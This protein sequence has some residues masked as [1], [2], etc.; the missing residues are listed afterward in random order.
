M[1]DRGAF[2]IRFK[3]SARLRSFLQVLHMPSSQ[4]GS[5]GW[6]VAYWIRSPLEFRGDRS[7]CCTFGGAA[8]SPQPLDT[9]E[10][11]WTLL[12]VQCGVEFVWL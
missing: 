7:S 9:G 2:D 12:S 4:H 1:L 8:P 3:L 11:L 10:I 5:M 6:M